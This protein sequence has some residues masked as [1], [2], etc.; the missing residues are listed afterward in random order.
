MT[1]LTLL[2]ADL[3]RKLC[4]AFQAAD[5]DAIDFETQS[6]F[7]WIALDPDL[8]DHLRSVPQMI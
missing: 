5:P 8:C 1:L 7:A 4:G 3:A 2:W 6:L